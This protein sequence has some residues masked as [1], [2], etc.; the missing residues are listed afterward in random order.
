MQV[1]Q[2]LLF[3]NA[4]FWVPGHYLGQKHPANFYSWGPEDAKALRSF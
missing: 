3:A 4:L 1:I 2:I